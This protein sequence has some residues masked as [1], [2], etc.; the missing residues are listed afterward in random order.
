VLCGLAGALRLQDVPALQR[1]RPGYA[2]FR[3]A[4]CA[5]ERAGALDPARVRALRQALLAPQPAGQALAPA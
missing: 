3:S 1:L 4:V 2:G 5:G